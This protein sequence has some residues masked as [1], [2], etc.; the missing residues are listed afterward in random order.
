MF[1]P[2]VVPPPPSAQAQDLGQ[3]IAGLVREYRTQN[4][5]VGRTDIEQAFTVARELVRKELGG[6]VAGKALAVMLILGLAA[7]TAGL[8]FYMRAAQMP[9][10]VPVLIVILLVVVG[11]VAVLMRR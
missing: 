1:V 3:R 8:V 2:V 5:G 10:F 11:V 6:L 4:P 9:Q 7:L